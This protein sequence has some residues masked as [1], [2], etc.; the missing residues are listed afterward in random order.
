MT[1]TGKGTTYP[2]IPPRIINGSSLVAQ[3][4]LS[5]SDGRRDIAT[6]K[7]GTFR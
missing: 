3:G 1:I 4:R 6:G 7:V 2:R 5:S